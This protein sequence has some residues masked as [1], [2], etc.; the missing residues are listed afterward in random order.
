MRLICLFRC[1]PVFARESIGHLSC[2][3]NFYK[4]RVIEITVYY[5]DIR[6]DIDLIGAEISV[7]HYGG[8]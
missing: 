5:L 3:I 7:T 8:D 2:Y 1:K 4:H 6:E